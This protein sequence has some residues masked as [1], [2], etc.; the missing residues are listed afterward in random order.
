MSSVVINEI[1]TWPWL[2]EEYDAIG[3]VNYSVAI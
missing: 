2:T 3:Q 1:T